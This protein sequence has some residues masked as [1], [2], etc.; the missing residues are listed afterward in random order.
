MAIWDYCA[1]CGREIP[2]DEPCYGIKKSIPELEGDTICKDCIQIENKPSGYEENL[3]Y[4]V[5]T[6]ESIIG[7]LKLCALCANT[8]C[9]N[10]VE[11]DDCVPKLDFSKEN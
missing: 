7:N 1:I 6:L 9:K 4:T 2:L 5:K 11:K 8:E 3:K 10:S